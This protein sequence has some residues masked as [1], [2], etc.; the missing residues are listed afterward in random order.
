MLLSKNKIKQEFNQL[1]LKNNQQVPTHFAEKSTVVFLE[2]CGEKIQWDG[3]QKQLGMQEN[4][5]MT[6]SATFNK[7][8]N[9]FFECRDIS[10]NVWNK[11]YYGCKDGWCDVEW[12]PLLTNVSWSWIITNLP[13]LLLDSRW[14]GFC[15]LNW[16]KEQ[17][18][19]QWLNML[20]I[21]WTYWNGGYGPGVLTCS[22]RL[23]FTFRGPSQTRPNPLGTPI[24][25]LIASSGLQGSPALPVM[26]RS[27]WYW[28]NLASPNYKPYK[29]LN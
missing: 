28:Y 9:D 20:D 29:G 7:D 10:R 6:L 21:I 2:V 24:L 4:N 8:H 14:Q 23:L 22:T 1:Y 17:A 11:L 27:P 18:V 26:L 12:R 16:A 15:I 13:G 3:E 25:K 19:K 5:P